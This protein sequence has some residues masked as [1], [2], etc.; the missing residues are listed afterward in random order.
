MPARKCAAPWA[1]TERRWSAIRA[2]SEGAARI[3]SL[4][5][6]PW[7]ERAAA[8]HRVANARFGLETVGVPRY[9]ALYRE[10]LE[11]RPSELTRDAVARLRRGAPDSQSRSGL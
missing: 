6:R 11:A 8:A 5:D 2:G 1:S 4:L 3:S 7:E 9:E 10:M